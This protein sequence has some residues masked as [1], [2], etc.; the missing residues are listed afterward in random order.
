MTNSIFKCGYYFLYFLCFHIQKQLILHALAINLQV[1]T[2]MSLGILNMPHQIVG[3]VEVRIRTSITG[4][5]ESNPLYNIM[6][7]VISLFT[8]SRQ[9]PLTIKII[10]KVHSCE[11]SN[12]IP[13]GYLS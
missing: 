9:S 5:K 3:Q 10:C 1:L 2:E 7:L 13:F 6:L 4:S 8:T 12:I 11:K